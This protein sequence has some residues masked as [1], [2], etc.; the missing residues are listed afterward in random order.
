MGVEESTRG[1]RWVETREPRYGNTSA[2]KSV[3][4]IYLFVSPFNYAHLVIIEVHDIYL[5]L[6]L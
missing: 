2:T 5:Y 4:R 1:E 3:G 6:S